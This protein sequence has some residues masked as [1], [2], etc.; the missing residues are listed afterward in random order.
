MI[1]VQD[2]TPRSRSASALRAALRA[3][4]SSV[5]L[6]SPDAAEAFW[7][8]PFVGAAVVAASRADLGL[9][10]FLTA[11]DRLLEW[12]Q[13]A[14][15]VAA[16]VFASLAARLFARRGL[17]LVPSILLLLGLACVFIAG[18]EISWGQRIFGFATP[19]ELEEVNKQGETTVHNIGP[20]LTLFNFGMLC[21]G[22]YGS[23]VAGYLRFR[24][25]GAQFRRRSDLLVPP[26]FLTSAFF[27]LFLYKV[28]R[29]TVLPKNYTTNEIGEWAE[30]SLAFALSMVTYLLW[31][32]ARPQRR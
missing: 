31:R 18:E 20:I 29:M 3:D 24:F 17:K 25:P 2:V 27:V 22:F 26:L 10:Q 12:L 32:V 30:F 5:W 16:T 1:E 13:F 15:F 14:G 7:L 8:L 11:E 6:L 4:A 23:A 19:E 9:F 28:A 21:L